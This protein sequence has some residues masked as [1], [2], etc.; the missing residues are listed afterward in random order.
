MAFEQCVRW[1]AVFAVS[2]GIDAG[3]CV[4]RSGIGF[5][6]D[7]VFGDH[8]FGIVAEGFADVAIRDAVVGRDWDSGVV[9][10]GA[11]VSGGGVEIVVPE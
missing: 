10:G 6:D 11:V 3:G 7:G 9:R 8:G 4:F 1:A 5:H 2:A